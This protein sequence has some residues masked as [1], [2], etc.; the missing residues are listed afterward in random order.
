M[1]NSRL[2]KG[3]EALIRPQEES[4]TGGSLTIKINKITPNPNQPRQQFDNDALDELVSSIKEK[5]ILTPVTVCDQ[6]G[7]YILIAGERRLRAAKIAGLTDIP[8]YIIEVKNDAELMEMA[9]IENIQRENLNPIEEAEAFAVLNSKF[10]LSQEAVAKAVGKKRVTVANALR[11]LKLPLEIKDSIK[12]GDI[13]A[14]HG[15]AIL[16]L[17]TTQSMEWLWQ[18]IIDKNLS[19]RSAETLAQSK[20]EN[21]VKTKIIK[22]KVDPRIRQLEDQLISAL[23]TKVKI[24]YSKGSGKIVV[25]YYSDDDFERI[26]SILTSS[27]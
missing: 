11:L 16:M 26:F 27:K 14:G 3:L 6:D 20:T 8:A 23:G 13:S 25:S 2:G 21:K 1:S 18:Q 5:G 22:T 19:V 24:S 10:S 4:E 12:N 17:K 9:L 7:K 15:R